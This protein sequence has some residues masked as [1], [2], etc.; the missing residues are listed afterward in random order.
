MLAIGTTNFGTIWKSLEFILHKIYGMRENTFHYS[1]EIIT[2]VGRSDGLEKS[3]RMKV[4]SLVLG[5]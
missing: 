2:N 3:L 4:S 1:S 5:R